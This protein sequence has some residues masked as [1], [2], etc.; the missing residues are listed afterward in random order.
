LVL[1]VASLADFE[2]DYEEDQNVELEAAA[3]YGED[4][5][6]EVVALVEDMTTQAD[7]AVADGFDLEAHV[8]TDLSH[9]TQET[10]D[11]CTHNCELCHSMPG[12]ENP[13]ETVEDPAAIFEVQTASASSTS[14]ASTILTHT[15]AALGGGAL[16][17]LALVTMRQFRTKQVTLTAPQATHVSQL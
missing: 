5:L 3:K 12:F 6:D 1:F 16:V 4:N 10:V 14:T 17:A 11:H 15:A 13:I 7:V 9:P 2:E 8:A